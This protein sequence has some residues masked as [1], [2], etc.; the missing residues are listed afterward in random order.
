MIITLKASE[1]DTENIINQ[2]SLI[3]AFMVKEKNKN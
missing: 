1:N 3:P 2:V